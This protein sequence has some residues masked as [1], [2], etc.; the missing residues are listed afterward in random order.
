MQRSPQLTIDQALSKAKKAIKKG[1][2]QSALELYS[3]ILQHQP[4]HPVAKK[5]LRK[6]QNS[7]PQTQ[8]AQASTVN[9]GQDQIN[10][11]IALFQSGELRQTE[12]ACKELLQNYPQSFLVCNVLGVALQAQGKL[13]EAVQSFGQAIQLKSDFAEAYC[14]HGS[15][16]KD[17][18]QVN[19]AMHSFDKAIQLKPDFVEAYNNRAAALKDLGQLQDAVQS[20]DKAIQ[21][22]PNYAEAYSNRGGALRDFG[23]LNEAV[24]SYDKAIEQNPDYVE[25]YI[26]RG[27]ALKDLG[28]LQ[29]AVESYNKAI[30]LKPDFAVAYSNRGNTL[31]ELGQLDDAMQ[32]FGKA[33]QLKPDY[34]EAFSNL[35]LLMNYTTNH[36][37]DD[38]IRMA[39]KFGEVFSEKAS[40]RFS[41]YNCPT[42]TEILRVGL[43]SGDLRNHSVGHFLESIL[44]SIDSSKI[45]LVAYPTTPEIDDLSERIKPFFSKWK[46]IY[47]Q[48]DEVVANLIH[49]DGIQILLDLSGHTAKNRLPVFA[50]K[51][52]PVQVSWLG[53]FDTTGLNE[54]DYVL[55]DPHVIPP[56]I[57]KQFTEKVWRLPETRW[58]FTAPDVG[59]EI[60]P[61]PALSNAYITFGCFNN[62]SK[63]NDKVVQLWAKIL[64]ALPS[65]K[66][67]LKNR[68]FADQSAREH[69]IYRFSD[70]G[71]DK[72]RINLEGPDDRQNYFAAYNRVDIT[73]DPFPFT[74]GTTSVESLWMG[75]P[76]LTLAGDSLVS[77]QGVGVLMNASLLEWIAES[78]EEYLT[79]AIHFA[80][81]TDKLASL[82]TEL[83]SQALA[84]PLFDAP[85]FARNIENALLEIWNQRIDQ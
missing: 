17:L 67:L 54:M 62:L 72:S 6:L 55:G 25:A 35:L 38:R 13:Q 84:S 9:P 57:E 31:K 21:L 41:T 44:S 61:L 36:D 27:V 77:R 53:Y 1:N 59:I 32:D 4:N 43:V 23:Q 51:P 45:E 39:R 37:A 70:L 73:L 42:D 14:N 34:A 24:L 64:T 69:M 82:R 15:A 11:L 50:Y 58:C 66:L 63:L 22:R 56:E 80:S 29:E 20:Y 30:Q 5:G 40:T 33:I 81:D 52:A 12:Q 74:G 85:R 65:S 18:G 68:Q 2:K 7:L 78:E 60:S 71:I 16:L 28:Q 47:G 49:A 3:A 46:S 75:V 8:A 10:K 26:N 76:L 83:R 19:E 48:E 79:R